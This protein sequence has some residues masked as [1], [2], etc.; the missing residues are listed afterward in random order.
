[1]TSY[2]RKPN[3]R[4]DLNA[5]E[6]NIQFLRE[7][8]GAKTSQIMAVIKKNAYGLGI[9][10]IGHFLSKLGIEFFAVAS[11]EEARFL[12]EVGID[13]DILILENIPPHYYEDAHR[14]NLAFALLDPLQ[15][16]SLIAFTKEK[17]LRLHLNI[18]SGM[19]R[20]GFHPEQIVNPEITTALKKLTP[21]I[22]GI[23]THFHSSDNSDKSSAKS[24]RTIF[25]EAKKT[26]KDMGIQTKFQHTGNSAGALAFGVNGDTHIRTGIAIY[27]CSPDS[28]I[29]VTGLTEAVTIQ[30][31]VTTIRKVRTGEGVGYGHS[32]QAPKETTIATV[33]L[34][35]ANGLPRALSGKDFQVLINGKAFPLV[36][37]VTMDYSLIDIGNDATV[38]VGDEVTFADQSQGEEFSIDA[39]AVT[40]NTIG[41]EELCRFG[42]GLRREYFHDGELIASEERT[43]F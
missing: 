21:F 7:H 9:R 14:L 1:M 19:R 4:I 2:S 8:T 3:M 28:S 23:Y 6:S 37:R 34:G 38:Q 42:L 11:M 15:L 5:I 30:S 33:S 20:N 26:L 31:E 39:L 35:Y 36:G 10:Q 25:E 18:D 16:P 24:Q 27:G 29:P 13:K 32:W 43:M 12:R 41:Y 22:E 17:S 40:T